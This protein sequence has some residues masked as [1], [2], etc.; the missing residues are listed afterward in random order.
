[1]NNEGNRRFRAMVKDE[2]RVYSAGKKGKKSSI[3]KRILR[4]IRS[5]CLDDIGFIK[6]DALTGRYYTA[7]ENAAKVTIAQAFRDALHEHGYKSSKQHKQHKRD[8]ANGKTGDPE[9]PPPVC[10]MCIDELQATK[11]QEVADK[12]PIHPGSSKGK[13]ES[14]LLF[15]EGS[16]ELPP[17]D[18][19]MIYA[20]ETLDH[21]LQGR[22]EVCGDSM[23]KMV[24]TNHVY[25]P[26]NMELF[27]PIPFSEAMKGVGENHHHWNKQQTHSDH[28]T[29]HTSE[30]SG[31]DT[32]H[33]DEDEALVLWSTEF[34]HCP[35]CSIIE[36][37]H[38]IGDFP[39]HDIRKALIG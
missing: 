33:T 5:N 37:E 19:S 34:V 31:D 29:D 25:H 11:E 26:G 7:N 23:M 20:H 35:R 2:L 22:A 8:I 24:D 30:S 32:E 6:Q 36:G 16:E 4:H 21:E 27:E 3:I 14:S 17:I 28:E 9:P 18:E 10:S 13:D 1:M 15:W 38:D 12:L 39:V